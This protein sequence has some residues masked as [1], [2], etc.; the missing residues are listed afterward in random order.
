MTNSILAGPWH[1]HVSA[2]RAPFFSNI[3]WSHMPAW[4]IRTGNGCRLSP[5][6][7]YSDK[8]VERRPNAL[9][10]LPVRRPTRNASPADFAAPGFSSKG[11]PPQ[12]CRRC[13]VNTYTNKEVALEC[14][15]C[16]AGQPSPIES[17]G[18]DSCRTCR[19]G[20]LVFRGNAD[21]LFSCRFCPAGQTTF[22]ENALV[23]DK[24][25][26]GTYS[27]RSFVGDLPV[28]GNCR[29]CRPGTFSDRPGA[30]TCKPCLLGQHQNNF[31]SNKCL[32]CSKGSVTK[33]SG[34]DQ[35][36]SDC[37]KSSR[38]CFSCGPGEGYNPSRRRCDKWPPGNISAIRSSTPCVPCPPGSQAQANDE[39]T[40]CVC[41]PGYRSRKNGFCE[42][43]FYG[44]SNR[45]AV[46]AFVL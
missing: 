17:K 7:T 35:C 3:H 42:R 30:V 24:C 11:E 22:K 39:R 9:P 16:P 28:R 26:P 2:S 18:E 36:R 45:A 21:K 38:G 4:N 6:N 40:K 43:C 41:Q 29:P 33:M 25:Y 1:C 14:K 12:P 13:P 19:I 44:K 27:T 15:H 20:T 37:D 32:V 10:V 34:R 23:C 8:Q 5:P 31:G 46:S